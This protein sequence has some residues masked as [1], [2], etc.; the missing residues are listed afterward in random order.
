MNEKIDSTKN[1]KE[2]NSK[3]EYTRPTLLN[4]GSMQ[5]VTLGGSQ[6]YGDSGGNPPLMNP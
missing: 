5:D 1:E 4:M 3:K 6:V 2:F